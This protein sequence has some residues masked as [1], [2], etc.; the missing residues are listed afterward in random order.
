A[1]D[2]TSWLDDEMAILT[3]TATY[4]IDPQNAWKRLKT[5]SRKPKYLAAVQT[6]A[7]WR[8]KTA[9]DN[10]VPRNRVVKDES[11]TE[12]AAHLPKS[13]E[14]LMSLRAISRDRI[15]NDRAREIIAVLAEV[16]KMDSAD[17]P[18]PPAER[19]DTSDNG[20]SM[21]LLKV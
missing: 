6:L 4:L 5:R 17:Y 11:I 3:N 9:Q 21:E 7:A 18:E 14:E 16:E 13:A 1:N 19:A 15:G 2:R 12:I 20:P 8:E 10:N